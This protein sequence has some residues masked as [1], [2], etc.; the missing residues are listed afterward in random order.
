MPVKELQVS[1]KALGGEQH[2][3]SAV[4]LGPLAAAAAYDIFADVEFLL[5]FSKPNDKFWGASAYEGE[6]QIGGSDRVDG[7]S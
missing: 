6:S 3:S 5:G 4:C 1:C 7:I 2:T